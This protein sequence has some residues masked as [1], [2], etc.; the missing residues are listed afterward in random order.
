MSYPRL[1]TYVCKSICWEKTKKKYIL[2]KKLIICSFFSSNGSWIEKGKCCLCQAKPG[3]WTEVYSKFVWPW[4]KILHLMWFCKFQFVKLEILL[5]DIT[6]NFS[7]GAHFGMPICNAI[8]IWN[9]MLRHCS[10]WGENLMKKQ[11]SRN[12]ARLRFRNLIV[13]PW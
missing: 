13:G 5:Q 8:W 12:I 1:L 10:F 7:D 11:G 9:L 6:G 3:Y 2:N 4:F